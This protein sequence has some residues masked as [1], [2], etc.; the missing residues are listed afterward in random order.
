LGM[1]VMG[2]CASS[3]SEEM[4][5][6]L[7]ASSSGEFDRF[8]TH[9]TA[10]SCAVL[11]GLR[12]VEGAENAFFDL[13]KS[14]GDVPRILKVE[15]K[16]GAGFHRT[17]QGTL[18]RTDLAIVFVELQGDVVPFP[19]IQERGRWRID[20]FTLKTQWSMLGRLGTLPDTAFSL[21]N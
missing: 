5:E 7:Q 10:D 20:L 4:T 1:S 2:G 19:M 18:Q 13:P 6:L 3:P 12:G 14:G 15:Q 16:S 8:C 9:F 21:P 11:R 17:D